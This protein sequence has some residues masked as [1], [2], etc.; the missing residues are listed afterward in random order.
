[1]TINI[2]DPFAL[3]PYLSTNHLIQLGD[4]PSVRV[5]S[6]GVSSRTVLVE[7]PGRP[8]FVVKQA[9][10]KLRVASDWFSPPDRIHR[11][12]LGM[13]CLQNLAPPGAITSLL[14]EDTSSYVIAMSAVPQPHRNWK[15]M[16]FVEP[17]APNHVEQ[18]AFILSQIHSKSHGDSSLVLIFGDQTNFESL[19]LEPYYRYSAECVP[20]AR[21]FLKQLIDDTAGRK[22]SLVHGDYS[23]KNI[24]VHE[25][26]FVL[27][28]HE[29]V[30][31]GDPAF[32]VGFSFTHL[33]SKALHL[34]SFR[35]EFLGAAQLFVNLY[36]QGVRAVGFDDDLE[37]M[38]CRHALACLLAR[39]A[40]RSPFEYLTARERAWQKRTTLKLMLR[41]VSRF[42]DLIQQFVE[43]LK[44]P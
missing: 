25:G 39:V 17:P 12:A 18:F 21:T 36:L 20:E 23:P 16:L 32:D 35:Q 27:V 44:C 34:N 6:G 15:E 31:F 29:V 1:M 40:G 7:V 41:P 13:R 38:A 19:R 8:S 14:F 30:H 9:L 37:P 26:K 33:L 2:E 5:L 43:E 4:R 3:L 28:D 42:V 24:L 10:A 11:E 22:L